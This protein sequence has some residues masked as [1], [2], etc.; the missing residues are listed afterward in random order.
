MGFGVGAAAPPKKTGNGGVEIEYKKVVKIVQQP[1]ACN[2]Q[3]G[4]G[5][6]KMESK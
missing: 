3:G 5:E 6:E 4:G 1:F 2:E